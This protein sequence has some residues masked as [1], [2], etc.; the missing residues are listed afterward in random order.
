MVPTPRAPDAV[1]A[2]STFGKCRYHTPLDRSPMI[3]ANEA[4]SILL[5]VRAPL[6]ASVTLFPARQALESVAC[7]ELPATFYEIVVGGWV[8]ARSAICRDRG[9]AVLVSVGHSPLQ[10]DALVD[11][12]R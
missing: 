4:R 11:G 3:A 5:R 8:G 9:G 1:G 2:L 12:Y 6:S 7:G 10:G